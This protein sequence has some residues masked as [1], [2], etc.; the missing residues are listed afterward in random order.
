MVSWPQSFGPGARHCVAVEACGTGSQLG[1]Q[2][3][4]AL[5]AVKQLLLPMQVWTPTLASAS[6]RDVESVGWCE[7]HSRLSL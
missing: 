5:G 7:Q 6:H 2:Q 4:T 3:R 1:S